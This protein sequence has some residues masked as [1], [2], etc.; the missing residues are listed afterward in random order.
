LRIEADQRFFRDAL[1]RADA[2]AHGRNSYEGERQGQ[3]RHRL[4]LTRRIPALERDPQ[5]SRAVLWNPSGASLEQAWH[6]LNPAGGTLVI[7]GGTDVYG[8][9]LDVGYSIFHLTQ[10]A[11]VR[12]PG[13]RPVFP[14]IPARSPAQ[15][16]AA[17]GLV[18]G[19]PQILDATAG[20]TLTTWR[21]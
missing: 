7:I 19:P 5:R 2:L 18:A 4:I 16:L 10:L 11:S 1:A 8:L 15:M 13:G 3:D 12:L 14:G 9:F 20:A 6:V 21:R 17:R